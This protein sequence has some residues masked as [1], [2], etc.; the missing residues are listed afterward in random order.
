[1]HIRRKTPGRRYRSKQREDPDSEDPD[2]EDPDAEDPDSKDPDSEAMYSAVPNN[3]F[4]C[5]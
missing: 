2:S 5:L 1:M 3:A 4:S